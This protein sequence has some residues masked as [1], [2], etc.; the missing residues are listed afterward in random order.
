MKALFMTFQYILPCD[1]I[2]KKIVAQNKALKCNGLD[3]ELACFDRDESGRLIY[4][5]DDRTI[6][7]YGKGIAA[8]IK[9]RC[10]FGKLAKYISDNDIRFVYVRYIHFANPF[11]VICS[12]GCGKTERSFFSNCPPILT[13]A[14]TRIFRYAR[15]CLFIRSGYAVVG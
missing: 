14:N 4:K 3:V 9:K 5:I 10:L 1:G 2:S 7:T 6:E 15:L 11:F 8:K 13:I 12:G